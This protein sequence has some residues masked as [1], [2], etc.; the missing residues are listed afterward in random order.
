MSLDDLIKFTSAIVLFDE[1]L[2]K[3][4]TFQIGGPAQILVIPRTV[5]DIQESVRYAK[6][7]EQR[8]HV[9]GNGSKLLVSD[10]GISGLT[11][12]I[13]G[14]FDNSSIS[15]NKLIAGAGC[16]LSRLI[17]LATCHALRGLEF[18]AGIPG[19]LGG[20]IAMNAGTSSGSISDVVSKVEAFN[21]DSGSLMTLSNGECNFKYRDSV[22]RQDSLIITSAELLLSNGDKENIQKTISDLLKKRADSQPLDKPNAG[23]IFKNPDGYSAAK[24]IDSAGLKGARIGQAQISDRHANFIVNLGNATAKDVITLV[25]LIQSEIKSRYGVSLNLELV[26]LSDY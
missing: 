22:F 15:G 19:T 18:A 5:D 12:K 17:S 16:H 24:L 2:Q 11:I 6:L 3:H 23:S 25:N 1:P 8:I 13:S 20:A 14:N 7:H 26:M 9:I 10:S 4:T 21:I